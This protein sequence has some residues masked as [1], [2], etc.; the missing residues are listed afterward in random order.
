[1]DNIQQ[2][3]AN[4][5]QGIPGYAGYQAK[6]RRRDNDRLV[7]RQL[8]SKFEEQRT[9]LARLTRQAPIEVADDLENID[10][11]LQRLVAR[12]STAPTGYAGWFD[13][14]QIVESD[15][16]QLTLCDAKLA[17][18]AQQFQTALDQIATALKTK[19]NMEDAIGA[20]GDL[21]DQLNQQFDQREQFLAQGKRPSLEAPAKPAASPLGALTGK[22]TAPAQIVALTNLRLK[23]AL[24]YGGNDYLVSGKITYTIPT[25]S[26]WAYLLNDNGNECWLRV[27]PGDEIAICKV[28]PFDV[29]TALPETVQ[30][31]NQTLTRQFQGT[32]N[33][34]VEGANGAR[35]GTVQYGK[36]IGAPDLRLWIE[37]YG[38]ET[39]TLWG[40]TLDAAE[41][42]SYRR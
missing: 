13:A 3:V 17:E 40:R 16:D 15:L 41:L 21:L 25:G 1:M 11:K 42:K 39:R 38:A 35:R 7:R 29:P 26:F 23:D 19:E 6:D 28:V 5:A 33:V 20:G 10:Q 4:I 36:Y 37:N 9:R 22:P 32:A 24:S 8:A 12:L 31:E 27:G 14:A 2:S 18:G 30:Y 34:A